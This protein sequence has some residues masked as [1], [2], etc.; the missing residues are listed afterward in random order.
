[1]RVDHSDRLVLPVESIVG[2]GGVRRE[3]FELHVDGRIRL[4]RLV[5]GTNQMD[6][7]RL[8]L[9]AEQIDTNDGHLQSTERR[10]DTSPCSAAAPRED[11]Q[12]VG[13]DGAFADVDEHL[14]DVNVGDQLVRLA[15]TT[16]TRLQTRNE[17]DGRTDPALV[18]WTRYKC[19][20]CPFNFT[21]TLGN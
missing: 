6:F 19:S 13:R 7:L 17:S 20:C 5:F 4:V 10:R 2:A 15:A 8:R 16:W 18:G 12:R 3:Q 1:M 21:L 14:L 9:V 11:L